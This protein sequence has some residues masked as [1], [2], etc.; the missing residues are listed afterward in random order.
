MNDLSFDQ[1]KQTILEYR[2][3]I[4]ALTHQQYH[5]Q[6]QKHGLSLE[7]FHLLI[8][9]DELDIDLPAEDSGLSI[10][11]IAQHIGN[12][13]NTIS[14]RISRLEKKGLVQR[15]RDPK[16]R[17]ICRVVFTE[18]GQKIIETINHA[19]D[20]FMLSDALDVLDEEEINQALCILEKILSQMERKAK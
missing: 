14:E 3:K 2:D 13:Q 8:E 16:D 10:G 17:R 20:A 15:I 5:A 12:A 11:K 9:L 1:K 4:N 18:E 19:A 7:Q 6:A